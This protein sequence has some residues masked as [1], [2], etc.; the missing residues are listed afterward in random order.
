MNTVVSGIFL[1]ALLAMVFVYPM[2][3]IALSS[4]GRVLVRDHADLVGRQRLSVHEAYGFL[5]KIKAGHIGDAPLSPDAARAHAGAR[6]L[7]YVGMSLFMVVLFIG[8]ADAMVSK[9]GTGG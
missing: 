8:L 2:Y 1:M 5:G 7:L 9:H 4:F 3:F 6:R